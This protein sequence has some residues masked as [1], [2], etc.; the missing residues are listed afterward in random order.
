[1]GESGRK[2]ADSIFTKIIRGEIPCA[3]V[4]ETDL[5]IAFLD[6]APLAEG[7]TLVIP[8]RQV[9]RLEELSPA[10]A[11]AIA[12]V[13]GPLA[14]RILKATGAGDYN[15][16]QNNG[17]AAGQVV[18]HVHFHII[19]RREG[20]G[21]GYRWNAQRSEPAKLAALAERIRADA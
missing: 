8:K 1:M 14:L 10:E 5:L 18:P 4:L 16:L 21:L 20:D 7:H 13:L 6:I 15:I 2:T 11:G 12:A 3:K 17:A 19:P 9:E